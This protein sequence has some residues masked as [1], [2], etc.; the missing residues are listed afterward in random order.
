LQDVITK[1]GGNLEEKFFEREDKKNFFT[2]DY[3]Y[4]LSIVSVFIDYT[5]G[6]IPLKF[7]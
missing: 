7:I 5:K 6:G 2:I 1:H 4:T 3:E